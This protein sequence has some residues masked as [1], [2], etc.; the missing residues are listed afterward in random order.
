MQA[1]RP[2]SE[3]NKKVFF[4][5]LDETLDKA[6]NK[7]D[8]IFLAGDLNIDTG[9]KSKDTNNYLCD[10]MDTFSL[11]NLIKVKTCYKSATG[12]ILDIMLTN[13]MRSFQK[14]SNVTTGIS[15]YHKLI[16][17]CPKAHFKKLPPK[18]I[19]YRD[20]K[21]F[22]KNFD[23]NLIQRKFYS[24]K[25]SYDLFTETFKSVVDHHAPQKKKFVRGND[26]PFMTK[27]LRETIMNRSRCKHKYLKFPSRENF[28]AM[29]SMKNKYNSLC[30][31]AKTQYLKKCTSKNSSNNKQF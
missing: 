30:E 29:K 18:K 21:N 10:F 26:A 14:T 31:K 24:Q 27:P 13:K 23:Q 7:Y 15:D 1:Y 28:L 5:E 19:V 8:N 11:N 9:D 22:N 17:T 20:Y 6:V 4:D 16:V 25:N 3:T 12:T 2:P